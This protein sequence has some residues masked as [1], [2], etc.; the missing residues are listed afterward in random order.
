LIKV[1]GSILFVTDEDNGIIIVA[2]NNALYQQAI[3]RK[4]NYTK[5]EHETGN[6]SSS[7]RSMNKMMHGIRREILVGGALVLPTK[8][9][10]RPCIEVI[11]KRAIIPSRVRV[12]AAD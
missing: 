7:H 2:R 4:Q 11:L 5:V 10:R 1:T 9:Y 6:I 12:V 8:S 3:V